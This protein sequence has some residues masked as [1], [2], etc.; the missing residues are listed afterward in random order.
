ME[1]GLLY[2][3]Q[4]TVVMQYVDHRYNLFDKKDMNYEY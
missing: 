3:N 2:V 1:L 4:K